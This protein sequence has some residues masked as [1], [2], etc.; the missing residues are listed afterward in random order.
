MIAAAAG[1]TYF[2]RGLGVALSGWVDPG[3]GFFRWSGA[4]VYALLAGLIAR[5][6]VLPQGMLQETALVDRLAGAAAALVVYRLAGNLLAGVAGGVAALVLLTL[7]RLP[8]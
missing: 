6:I 2:W 4:V 5:M 1:V 3:S 8:T 7:W